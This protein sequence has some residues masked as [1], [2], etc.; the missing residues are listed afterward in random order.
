MS[1]E[2]HVTRGIVMKLWTLY[3]GIL[4]EPLF[5]S[6]PFLSSIFEGTCH[7]TA[8]YSQLP[9]TP[10]PQSNAP[11]CISKFSDFEFFGKL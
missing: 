10:I 7:I 3:I 2:S 4:W 6:M 1:C 11:A 5:K 8:L 9:T